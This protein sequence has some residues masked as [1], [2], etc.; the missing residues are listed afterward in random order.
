MPPQDLAS[1]PGIFSPRGADAGALADANAGVAAATPVDDRG[2]V[3]HAEQLV[4]H[5]LLLQSVRKTPLANGVLRGTPRGTPQTARTTGT[6]AGAAAPSTGSTGPRTRSRTPPPPAAAPAAAA[7]A[8]TAAQTPSTPLTQS[9]APSE[10]VVASLF[11]L[12]TAVES[13][14]REEVKTGSSPLL[15]EKRQY[16]ILSRSCL[17]CARGDPAPSLREPCPTPSGRPPHA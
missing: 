6:P 3:E 10:I 8:V 13:S 11:D 15:P 17:L 7:A 1:P 14:I 9:T 2:T 4:R 12:K 16:E 5:R